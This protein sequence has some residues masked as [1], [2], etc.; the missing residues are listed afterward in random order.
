[1]K[2]IN[3]KTDYA[4]K[5]IFGSNQSK[6][7]LLSFLNAI[8]YE[9]KEVIQDLEI[10]NPYSPGASFTLKDTYLDVKAKL[11][12]N[13]TVLIEM[14]VLNQYAFDKRVIY[15]VAKSYSNQLESG[16]RYNLLNPVIGVTIVDFTLFDNSEKIINSFILQEKELKFVYNEEINL[17]FVEL[18]KFNKKLEELESVADKWL[19]FLRNATELKEKPA[20]FERIPS[21]NKALEI[22]NLA[23]LNSEEL[24]DIQNRAMWLADQEG[25]L[26][27]AQEE[28]RKETKLELIF[29]LLKQKLGIISLENRAKIEPSSIEQLDLIINSILTLN[30]WEDLDQ[31]LS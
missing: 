27:Y 3:P 17:V 26:F 13:T 16:E 11:D 25:R 30:T 5:R 28:A 20:S 15:N 23:G 14:Q 4:F 1:M 21:L 22:A 24:D 19:Y 29:L 12:N 9:D 6:E 8:L 2:F 31:L 7:I 18:R 10:L